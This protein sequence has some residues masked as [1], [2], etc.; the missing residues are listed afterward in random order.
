MVIHVHACLCTFVTKNI[1]DVLQK[2]KL[3]DI[4][5]NIFIHVTIIRDKLQYSTNFIVN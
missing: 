2:W 1:S 4:K 3:A 5:Q